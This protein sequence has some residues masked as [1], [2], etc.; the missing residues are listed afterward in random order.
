MRLV[1]DS[2]IAMAAIIRDSLTRRLMFHPA[3]ELFSP[4]YLIEELRE[5]GEEIA[6]KASFSLAEFDSVAADIASVVELLA[7]P[8]FP[9]T[10]STLGGFWRTRKIFLS[11][12]LRS[13]LMPN[14]NA[15]FGQTTPT[16]QKSARSSRK[17][18]Q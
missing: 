6:K 17:N 18:S 7:P 11:Q 2:N 1:V 3:L 13:P 12:Q 15:A 4:T 5:H 10:Y 9:N 8:R 16:L 14:L